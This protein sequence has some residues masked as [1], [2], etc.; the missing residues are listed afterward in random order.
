MSGAY[1]MYTYQYCFLPSS[2]LVHETLIASNPLHFPLFLSLY[3]LLSLSP[4][5]PA[6]LCHRLLQWPMGEL[7]T[8]VK[9]CRKKTKDMFINIYF[10]NPPLSFIFS[11][12]L[13]HPYFLYL[14]PSPLL[15]CH[16]VLQLQEGGWPSKPSRDLPESLTLVCKDW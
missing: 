10:I 11:F 6:L 7:P 5:H 9:Q 8:N 4:P 3:C 16:R 2:V 12:V 15:L 1:L 14:P 13:S